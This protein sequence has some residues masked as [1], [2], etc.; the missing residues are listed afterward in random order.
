MREIRTEI[1]LEASAERV[2]ELL[3]D[4]SLYPQWNPLFHQATGQKNAGGQLELIVNLPEISP[5]VVRPKLLAVEPQTSY[6][7]RYTW[8]FA[9]LLTWK[10]SAALESLAPHRLKFIQSSAFGGI[11]GP[12]FDLSLRA[13]VSHGLEQMNKAIKRWGEKGGIQCLRC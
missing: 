7:W 2:W 5:F 3:V 9:G 10:Y 12:L 6:C 13:S 1:A 11:L 4:C 8:F